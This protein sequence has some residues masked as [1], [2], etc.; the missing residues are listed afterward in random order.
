MNATQ[1]TIKTIQ[2]LRR[3]FMRMVKAFQSQGIL[4]DD[5]MVTSDGHV[6]STAYPLDDKGQR[7]SE[8]A[9]KVKYLEDEN[10]MKSDVTFWLQGATKGI[11]A[12]R[13]SLNEQEYRRELTKFISEHI[14]SA[15]KYGKVYEEEN[16]SK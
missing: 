2:N 16:T 5:P 6:V 12:K 4:F 11:P 8:Q 13:G 10:G 14:P 7:L 15:S 9:F 3:S 1:K